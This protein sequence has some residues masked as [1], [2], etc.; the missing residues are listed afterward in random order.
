[1][2]PKTL[3]DLRAAMPGLDRL[4]RSATEYRDVI[5][6]GR[7]A[8]RYCAALFGLRLM[9]TP[10]SRGGDAIGRRGERVE[11]KQRII[12]GA[13]PPGMKID[14]SGVDVVYYVKLAPDLLPDCI[15]R[16]ER[17]H[18]TATT[19]GRVSFAT[20]IRDG[21]AAVVFSRTAPAAGR[22]RRVGALPGRA[23]RPSPGR[24]ARFAI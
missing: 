8:E 13:T 2:R 11:I 5:H 7:L 9:K 23:P 10:N 12:R 18:I 4:L 17:K 16:I 3:T 24:D 20:A 6:T 14:L 21:A 1:M 22:P 19:N 15:Y